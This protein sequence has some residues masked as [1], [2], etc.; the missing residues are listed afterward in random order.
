MRHAYLQGTVLFLTC[1][2]AFG[3]FLIAADRQSPRFL[4]QLSIL[5]SGTVLMLLRVYAVW[6]QSKLII[7]V[8]LLVLIPTSIAEF[9]SVGMFI[10]PTVYSIGMLCN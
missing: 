10:S 8:L 3:V 4:I 7:G 6:G 2:S 5:T 9:V 1:S